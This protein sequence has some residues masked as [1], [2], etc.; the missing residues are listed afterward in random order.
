MSQKL[1]TRKT[2]PKGGRGKNKKGGAGDGSR[3]KDGSS[4]QIDPKLAEHM[5]VLKRKSMMSEAEIKSRFKQFQIDCP[6]G[7][8]TRAKFLEMTGEELG[9]NAEMLADTIFKVRIQF[10]FFF[11]FA[12]LQSQRSENCLPVPIYHSGGQYR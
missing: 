6:G 8:L 9:E 10:P 2:V 5:V 3:N 1:S 4:E 12:T 7:K 11:F